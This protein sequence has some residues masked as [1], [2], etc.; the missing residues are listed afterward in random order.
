MQQLIKNQCKNLSRKREGKSSK[1][2]FLRMV[3]SLNF[4]VKTMFFDCLEGCMREQEKS[5]KTI[6]NDVKI[7]PKIDETFMQKLCSKK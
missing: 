2:M 4:I 3:K 5:A 7:H 1:N 6:K